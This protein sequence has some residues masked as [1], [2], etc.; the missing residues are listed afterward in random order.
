M[1]RRHGS[2]EGF[3]LVELLIS[4][5]IASGLI[6]V[7]SASVILGFRTTEESSDQIN[8]AAWGRIIASWFIADVHA[9]SESE[10]TP[11]C[12]S[13]DQPAD[14]LI[15]F[16]RPDDPNAE[17]PDPL[18]P[19][20]EP[21]ITNHTEWWFAAGS[22]DLLRSTCATEEPPPSDPGDDY[23]ATETDVIATDLASLSISCA[24]SASCEVTWIV[25]V[26]ED[27]PNRSASDRTYSI[28]VSRRVQ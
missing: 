6:F 12:V 4:L 2:D 17:P 23:P 5:G 10:S 16:T 20:A 28:T 3:T 19:E 8:E 9:V 22:G 21:L 26:S 1:S 27:A 14:M 13:P 15:R 7:V 24:G 18:D 11:L 25:P